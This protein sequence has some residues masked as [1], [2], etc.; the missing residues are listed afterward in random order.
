MTNWSWAS[1]LLLV[2][3]GVNNTPPAKLC[4]GTGLQRVSPYK[5]L[6]QWEGRGPSPLGLG[7]GLNQ[8]S[9][10]LSPFL[11]WEYAGVYFEVEMPWIPFSLQKC[12][13]HLRYLWMYMTWS[14]AV[15]LTCFSIYDLFCYFS[16]LSHMPFW[17]HWVW[18]TSWATARSW[19]STTLQTP[20]PSPVFLSPFP[21]LEL[22]H[23]AWLQCAHHGNTQHSCTLL[24]LVSKTATSSFSQPAFA[25]EKHSGCLSL[26]SRNLCS[27]WSAFEVS[28]AMLQHAHH[29]VA[30]AADYYCY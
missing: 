9:G 23:E 6:L 16:H 22:K 8:E 17:S 29:Q 2:T 21:L 1:L 25:E 24:M 3:T 10:G 19:G 13:F 18:D 26:P 11:G 4:A 5:C 7:M 20:P 15:L 28:S 27:M 14:M 12:P 30:A